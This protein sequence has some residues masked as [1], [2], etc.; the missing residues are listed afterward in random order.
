MPLGNLEDQHQ[1]APFSY[2]ECVVILHQSAS[3]IMYLHGRPAP[4]AHRDIKPANI[5]VQHRDPG[6]NALHI[7]LSDFGLA[8]AGSSLKTG[9]PHGYVLPARDACYYDFWEFAG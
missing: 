3:A 4:V 1:A 8:K 2:E 5:L 6:R 7:K 9:L